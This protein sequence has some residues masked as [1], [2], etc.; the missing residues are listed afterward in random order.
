MK[1][2]QE[3][4]NFLDEGTKFDHESLNESKYLEGE[5]LKKV[6]KGP[7]SAFIKKEFKGNLKDVSDRGAAAFSMKIPNE[8]K[9]LFKELNIEVLNLL[10]ESDSIIG[11]LRFNYSH[12]EGSNGYSVGNIQIKNNKVK[13]Y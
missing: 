13:I 2:K 10:K 5:E 8:M 1:T 11:D 3:I 12:P 6:I 4:F 7:V 9:I